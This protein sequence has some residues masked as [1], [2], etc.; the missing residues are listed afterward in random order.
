V[1]AGSA[2]RRTHSEYPTVLEERKAIEAVLEAIANNDWPKVCEDSG[3]LV[4]KIA[5]ARYVEVQGSRPKNARAAI[6]FIMDN[7]LIARPLG[8]KMH[9]VRELRNVAAH[10]GNYQID[11][12]DAA[13]AERICKQVVA[14]LHGEKLKE[15]WHKI[16]REFDAGVRSLHA[17]AGTNDSRGLSQIY[18]AMEEAVSLKIYSLGLPIEPRASFFSKLDVLSDAGIDA[19]WLQILDICSGKHW[20]SSWH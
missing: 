4:E 14:W 1:A 9:L 19:R 10:R 20:R 7:R 11:R 2:Q 3:K 12:E 18:N 6:D 17:K 16:I 15:D 5:I 13:M 8:A